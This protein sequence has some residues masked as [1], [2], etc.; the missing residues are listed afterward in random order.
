MKKG[1]LEKNVYT[2]KQRKMNKNLWIN[3]VKERLEKT[4]DLA[5]LFWTLH[6]TNTYLFTPAYVTIPSLTLRFHI[7]LIFLIK[8][9]IFISV[10]KILY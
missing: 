7:F 8:V 2:V 6:L 5:K 4:I 9:H 10:S 3:I 1:Y